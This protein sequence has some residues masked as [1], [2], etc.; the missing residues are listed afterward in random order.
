MWTLTW[1]ALAL[2]LQVYLKA[3][4]ILNG[5]CVIWKGWIDLQRLDGMGYLEYDDER[6]QHEDALAQAAFEEARR[7]TRDFE[8]RE[9][10]HR[11]DLESRRQQDP[12]PGS[13]MANADMEHKMR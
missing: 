12:S 2:S 4:M 10:S 3:P 13:N 5:V 11:E 1:F 9:R 8:D 7:R 6:A